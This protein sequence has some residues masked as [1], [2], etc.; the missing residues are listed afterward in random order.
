MSTLHLVFHKPTSAQLRVELI[1]DMTQTLCYLEIFSSL[2]SL[3][4]TVRYTA[5]HT[6]LTITKS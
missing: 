1:Q 2:Y 4:L 5:I 6:T 3:N